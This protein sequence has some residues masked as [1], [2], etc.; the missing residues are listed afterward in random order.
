[1]A[2]YAVQYFGVDTV[3]SAV[4]CYFMKHGMTE[5]VRD[6][7]MAMEEENGDEF[8]QMVADHVEENFSTV[9]NKD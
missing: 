1:M 2:S 3:T 4:A 7:L 8:F 9:R 5:K 6:V